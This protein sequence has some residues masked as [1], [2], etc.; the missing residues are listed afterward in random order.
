MAGQVL[1]SIDGKLKPGHDWCMEVTDE[2]R[3]PLF[4]CIFQP[5]SRAD[6]P[7]PVGILSSRMV[8]S[9]RASASVTPRL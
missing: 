4:N 2:F 8:V 7:Y 5:Q 3:N 6:A 1:Q 9:E